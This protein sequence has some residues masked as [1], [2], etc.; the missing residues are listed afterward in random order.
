MPNHYK[1]RA[2]KKCPDGMEH[3]MS[4]G[5][6]MCGEVHTYEHGGGLLEG[7]SHEEGGIPVIVGGTKPIELEGGEYIIN[8]ETVKS[9]GVEFLDKIN[10]T[11]TSH[12]PAE[13][14]FKEGQLPSPSGYAD[15]GTIMNEDKKLNKRIHRTRPKPV[16]KHD[17]RAKTYSKCIGGYIVGGKCVSAERINNLNNQKGPCPA[18]YSKSADGSC[19]QI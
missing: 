13:G 15:G 12:W 9:L 19:I 7:P 5:G 3:Q 14:G 18:G 17:V 11:S 2:N 8:A 16:S 6:W 10:S 4:N 1:T